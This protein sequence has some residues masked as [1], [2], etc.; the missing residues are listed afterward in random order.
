[1]LQGQ[2]TLTFVLQSVVLIVINKTWK[3]VFGSQTQRFVKHVEGATLA[4]AKLFG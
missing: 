4:N 1:L 3:S 2:A